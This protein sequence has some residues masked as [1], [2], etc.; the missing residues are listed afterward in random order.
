MDIRYSRG[1]DE[2]C[3]TQWAKHP[4]L[5][6]FLACRGD[7]EIKN[8]CRTWIFFAQKQAGLSVVIKDTN[9]GM[10]VLILMPYQKVMH[11]AM[12]QIMVDPDQAR[13]GVGSTLLKNILHLAKDYL[14][15]EMVFM[16]LIG[17]TPHLSFFLK[18][19]FKVYAEQ[20]GY[21]QG[22]HPDK[23]LLEYSLI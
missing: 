20:K 10:G 9:V 4:K 12:L 3:L 5:Q 14:K 18:R 11:H 21:V 22:S 6:P 15:L 7:E 16:E 17:P 19:G 1:L 23:I 13:Q 2:L 8:F